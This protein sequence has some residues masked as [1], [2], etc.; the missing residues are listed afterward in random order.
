MRNVHPKSLTWHF[1]ENSRNILKK[2]AEVFDELANELELEV[3]IFNEFGKDSIKNWRVSPD[4][5]IQLIMQLAHYKLV[6]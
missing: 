6:F 4:G 5:F 3:L 1:S 2:Q